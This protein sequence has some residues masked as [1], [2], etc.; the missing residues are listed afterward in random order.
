MDFGLNR[1]RGQMQLCSSKSPCNF[2]GRGSTNALILAQLVR[3]RLQLY[4][5]YYPFDPTTV[6]TTPNC[7]T[8]A[9][10]GIYQAHP[11][12]CLFLM[13][14]TLSPH[15]H[16]YIFEA[17]SHPF[18][19]PFPTIRKKKGTSRQEQQTCPSP[20]KS[21]QSHMSCSKMHTIHFP[22]RRTAT[23]WKKPPPPPF[24]SLWP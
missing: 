6:H 13:H 11:I 7:C 21:N 9:R 15:D 14:P 19:L 3:L 16:L 17:S 8:I 12:L 18:F 4:P 10:F 23:T 1:Y 22:T 20:S 5:L 2:S 24:P